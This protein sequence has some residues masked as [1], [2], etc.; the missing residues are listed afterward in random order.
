MIHVIVFQWLFSFAH[1]SHDE[2]PLL[3]FVFPTSYLLLFSRFL[4]F[5]V[6]EEVQ[7]AKAYFGFLPLE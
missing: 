1:Q 5:V 6:G 7:N 2:E 3:V 4:P